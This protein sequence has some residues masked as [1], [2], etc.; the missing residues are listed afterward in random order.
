MFRY[1]T[2]YRFYTLAKLGF[3][4]GYLWYIGD[5]FRIHVAIWHQLSVLPPDHSE[6]IFS[7]NSQLDVFLRPAA[8]FL[9]GKAMA[10]VFVLVSPMAA[11]LY[12]WGRHR[13]LQLAVG[14][15]MSFSMISLTA[16]I[17]VFNTT[18]NIWLNYI[19]VFYSLTALICF[20]DEWENRES[21]FSLVKWRNNPALSSTYAWLVVLL[22][23]SVYFYAG[24]NKLLDGWVPW[25]TGVACLMPPG[26]GNGT[27]ATLPQ[28]HFGHQFRQVANPKRQQA[29][30]VWKS[31]VVSWKM[32]G[33]SAAHW[34]GD[35]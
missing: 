9:G 19:F 22:Q 31:A 33:T 12:V 35:Q 29:A 28:N 25:T 2:S 15:W 32:N 26:H 7:G 4:L 11:G 21:G 23:F 8:V 3:G 5:F 13:W 1:L 30:T 6:V 34:H 17:G 10:W 16:L 20:T 14:C 24:I 18:A 27:S